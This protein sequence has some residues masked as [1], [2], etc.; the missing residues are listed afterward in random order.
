MKHLL[1]FL[2]LFFSTQLYAQLEVTSDT[3]TVDGKNYGL[4]L[5]SY[6]KHSK[7]KPL[8]LF[9][10]A[11][12]DFYKVDKNIQECYKNHKIEYTDFY[13]LSIEGGNTNPYFN[14]I[15]EKGLNKI[16]ETRMSK[17][18]STLQIQYKEY[19]NEADKTWKIVYDKNN[20]TEI[21]KIKNLYQDISTKNIC[22][23]LKQSL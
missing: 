10:C 17:K 7:S 1:L 22:K 8:K 9:V 19:Y 3:I 18:L 16:D 20:L 14:Q 15:L 6:G 5:L 4:T 11:K 12:K 13:I 23:L 2:I 21:S